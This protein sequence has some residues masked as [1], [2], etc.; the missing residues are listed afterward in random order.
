MHPHANC[1]YCSKWKVEENEVG[2]NELVMWLL[3]QKHQHRS[4]QGIINGL[5]KTWIVMKR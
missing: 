3:K 5:M 1:P 2:Y 4:A